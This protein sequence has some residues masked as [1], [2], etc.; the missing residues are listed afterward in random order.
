MTDTTSGA[1]PSR[2]VPQPGKA[3]VCPLCGRER[4]E[5]VY[6][7]RMSERRKALLRDAAD[8]GSGL[9]RAARAFIV[10]NDGQ[11][12]PKGYEVSHETPLYTRPAAKRCELDTAENMRTQRKAEHRGRHKHC[13][14]QFHEHPR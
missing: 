10:A 13:G 12:V 4:H 1:K 2:F 8:S 11:R 6:R 3:G 9:S 7:R 5:R 14:D